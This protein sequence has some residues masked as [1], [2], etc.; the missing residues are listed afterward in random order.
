MTVKFCVLGSGSSG[1]CTFIGT[2]KTRI[3]VDAGLSARRTAKRLAEIGE[4]AETIN[5]ICVSHEH[6]DHIA[7]IRVLQ[8]NNRIPV[9][10]NGGTLEAILCSRK[11]E[12]LDCR[13]FTTGSPF[14]I[15]DLSIEPFS[16]PHDAYEPVGFV[17]RA[18]KYSIGI[19][20]DIGIVTNLVREKLR[21]C[22]V[23]VIEANHDEGLL[24]EANRPWS[25]K[26]RIRG[27][28]GHLS[29]RAAA[30]LMAEI[31]GEGLQHLFLAHLS[32]DCNS[33]HHARTTFETLLAAAGHSHV[34]V[35]L[36]GADRVS[37]PLILE[38]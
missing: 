24:H 36:T 30:A 13:R 37:E 17:I 18:G 1:N 34:T 8:K 16:V 28:Q 15:G 3:L 27:N 23:V 12:G 38:G 26:Q 25:L 2:E 5:A 35:G 29:N 14:S 21:K 33:P 6:G 22:H 7:G 19:A 32:A 11:H 9:Y 4:R 20:T 10:A 31:A